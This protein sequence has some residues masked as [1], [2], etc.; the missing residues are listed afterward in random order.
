MRGKERGKR[1]EKSTQTS[2]RAHGFPPV[3]EAR[4][5]RALEK[6]HFLIIEISYE[7]LM[8]E[9]GFSLMIFFLSTQKRR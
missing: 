6:L 5:F 7:G 1:E 3:N 4:V 2:N 8:S 9:E